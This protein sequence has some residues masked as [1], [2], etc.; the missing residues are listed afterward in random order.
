MP[1]GKQQANLEWVESLCTDFLLRQRQS[2]T[3]HD[4]W[5]Y[6]HNDLQNL[7]MYRSINALSLIKLLDQSLSSSH[8]HKSQCPTCNRDRLHSIQ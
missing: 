4:V 3:S 7:A 6:R 8:A 2:L 5:I 1:Q